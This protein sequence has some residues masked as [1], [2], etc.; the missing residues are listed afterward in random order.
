MMRKVKLNKILLEEMRAQEAE[1][2]VEV[3]DINEKHKIQMLNERDQHCHLYSVKSTLENLQLKHNQAQEV[4]A[5]QR[6]EINI[7]VKKVCKYAPKEF[8]DYPVAGQAN[9][10]LDLTT[11]KLTREAESDEKL[12]QQLREEK[13]AV[14]KGH[15]TESKKNMALEK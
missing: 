7:M 1:S 5:D 15:R 11:W 10:P 14:V 13:A 6:N 9:K 8:S 4:I 3:D 12:I 2:I